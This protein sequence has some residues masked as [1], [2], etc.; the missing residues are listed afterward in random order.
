MG[1]HTDQL[2]GALFRVLADEGHG[3][4]QQLL[5]ETYQRKAMDDREE[6]AQNLFVDCLTVLNER[7]DAE[8]EADVLTTAIQYLGNRLTTVIE[9]VP[10]AIVVVDTD[11]AIQLWN[12]GAAR[13]FGWSEAEMHNRQYPVCLTATPEITDSFGDRLRSG[14]SLAGIEAQHRHRNGSV[15][16]VRIWAAPLQDTDA[17]FSGATFAISDITAQK[18]RAQRLSV[19]NRVLRHNIRTDINVIQGHLSMLA[20]ELPADNR[21]VD[22]MEQRLGNITELSEAARCIDQ[23]EGDAEGGVTPID[24]GA[25]VDERLGR[26]EADYPSAEV[27]ASV[28]ETAPAVAHDL[29][30]Y[31]LDNVLENAVIHNPSSTPRVDVTVSEPTPDDDY[32]TLRIAD[33]GPGLP[34]AEREVLTTDTETPLSHSSGVGLWLT[35]WIVRSADGR[36]GVEPSASGGTCIVVR[37]LRPTVD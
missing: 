21:H 17:G 19:L 9:A 7:L 30:P 14:E 3:D 12:D 5:L 22:V 34:P 2:I 16:D 24:L 6:L 28:P 4:A 33:D 8:D 15:L 13:M 31:A 27:T 32:L 23:L 20:D 26:L 18:Q 29:L 37:L 11:G 1:G 35:R 25:I 36:V 10:I